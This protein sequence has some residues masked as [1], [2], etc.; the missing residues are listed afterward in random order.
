M[1]GKFLVRDRRRG[2]PYQSCRPVCSIALMQAK[3]KEFFD[4]VG[5]TNC[6]FEIRLGISGAYGRAI[7]SGL[8]RPRVLF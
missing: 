8:F 2:G 6:L 1:M 4:R 5:A 3:L 7:V